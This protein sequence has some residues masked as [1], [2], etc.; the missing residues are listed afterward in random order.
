M[1][2]RDRS[3]KWLLYKKGASFFIYVTKIGLYLHATLPTD[4][5]WFSYVQVI[6]ITVAIVASL[7]RLGSVHALYY[8]L[9]P[10]IAMTSSFF[11]AT[12]VF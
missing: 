8:S 4:A 7:Q 1:C 2:I 3:Y 5:F 12:S 6:L 10:F 9:T 11:Y